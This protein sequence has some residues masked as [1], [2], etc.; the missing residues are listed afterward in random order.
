MH[1]FQIQ[2]WEEAH[3]QMDAWHIAGQRLYQKRAPPP[4]A[5]TPCPSLPTPLG[6]GKQKQ[7][8]HSFS[9]GSIN[10]GMTK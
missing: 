2:T 5:P 1:S 6:Q 7:V 10:I 9:P 8:K 4:S 3:T